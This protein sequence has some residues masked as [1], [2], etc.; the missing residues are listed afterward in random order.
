MLHQY[1]N[2]FISNRLKRFCVI[3]VVAVVIDVV[4]IAVVVIS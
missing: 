4:V 1:L 2:I 3:V